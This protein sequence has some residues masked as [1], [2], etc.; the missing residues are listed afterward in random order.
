MGL[1]KPGPATRGMVA[2]R[3]MPHPQEVREEREIVEKGEVMVPREVS[4]LEAHSASH[5]R[6]RCAASHPTLES[7]TARWVSP[8]TYTR[9]LTNL[10]SSTYPP[11]LYTLTTRGTAC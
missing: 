8:V 2:L 6:R 9:Q 5:S 11:A 1:V 3:W 7:H 10:Q 4:A